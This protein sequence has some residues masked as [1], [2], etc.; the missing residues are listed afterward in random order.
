[1]RKIA[2]LIASQIAIALALIIG[3]F[4][5]E[6]LGL[7]LA[8]P[9]VC[10]GILCILLVSANVT[11]NSETNVLD[12]NKRAIHI[13]LHIPPSRLETVAYFTFVGD[14]AVL[15]AAAIYRAIYSQNYTNVWFIVLGNA[16]LVYSM[17]KTRLR[18]Q[19]LKKGAR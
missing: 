7:A 1:M 2:Y 5:R 4:V 18:Y 6:P 13:H 16:V 12:K 19:A 9:V 11:V 3:V 10:I 8:L 15:L 14:S 17:V